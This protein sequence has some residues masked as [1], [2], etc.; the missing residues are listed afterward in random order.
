ME[1]AVW[2]NS[3]LLWWLALCTVSA[4]NVG[5]LVYAGRLLWQRR[6][7]LGPK[8]FAAR[9]LQWIFAGGYVLGCAYRSCLPVFD[10]QRMVLFDTWFSSVVVGRSVATLAELCFVAQWALLMHEISQVTHSRVGRWASFAVLPLIAIAETCSWYSVLT[11][12]NIG[13]VMEESLWGLS[14]GLLVACLLSMWSRCAPHLRALLLALCLTGTAYVAFM[15]LVDVPM[16]WARWVADEASGRQY[17]TLSQGLLDTST[18]WVVSPQWQVWRTEMLW[19]SLYFSV[20]VWLSL[21]FTQLPRFR[22]SNQLAGGLT[23]GP[24]R[25]VPARIRHRGPRVPAH[26][27]HSGGSMRRTGE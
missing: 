12:S 15:F 18:R 13:H 20:A 24:S 26:A 23:G 1:N 10:V 9:R 3:V 4:F 27:T 11:T 8:T 17:L 14:A 21:G 19:M 16:Y 7:Q 22:L 5:A 2:D 6:Q 25:A